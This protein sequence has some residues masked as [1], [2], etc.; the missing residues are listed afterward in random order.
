MKK[1]VVI[2]PTYNEEENIENFLTNVLAQEGRLTEYSLE[3]LVSDSH[4]KDKTAEI[5][6]K[7]SRKDKRIHYLDVKERGLGLGL[8]KGLNHAVDRLGA[9]ILITMEADL[10]NDPNKIVDFLEKLKRADIVVGSRY[11]HGGGIVNWSWWRK[12]L[13]LVA[14]TFLKF[15]AWYPNLNEYTNLYRCFKKV[16]WQ[17]MQ[18]KLSP[19]TG[20]LFVPAFIFVATTTKFKIVEQPFVFYDRF[21]GRSKM[22]TL[23]YTKNLVEYA[24]KFRVKRIW[25]TFS[26]S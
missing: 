5:V 25:N 21:G 2:A 6:Q 23:S 16:V 8:F 15:M 9:D 3:I 22:H 24:I 20:W 19:Y 18:E 11:G 1:V 26:N 4:S 17:Q 13:S 10:S 12:T 14:N 7:L